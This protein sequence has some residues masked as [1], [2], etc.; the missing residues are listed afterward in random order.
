MIEEMEDFVKDLVYMAP[1]KECNMLR[2]LKRAL[3][4]ALLLLTAA[5]AATL[6]VLEITIESDEEIELTVNE[7]KFLSDELRRQAV[8]LLPKDYS[9]LTREKIIS[10]IPENAENLS[11]A[12]DIGKAIKSDYVT[13][14]SIDKLGGLFMLTVEL[15]ETSSG[16]ILGEFV[17]EAADYKGLL[18]AIREN[19]PNLF[20]KLMPETAGEPQQ[21]AYKAGLRLGAQM[22]AEVEQPASIPA[23]VPSVPKKSKNSVWVAIGLDALGAAALGLG[24]YSYAKAKSYYKDCQDLLADVPNSNEHPDEYERRQSDFT[25]KYGKVQ[26]AEKLRNIFYATGGALLSAGLAVHIWF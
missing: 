23:N 14:G 11:T 2:N 16:S 17:K 21:A 20:A 12:I 15:Y 7:T 18:D 6:A 24:V 13:R 1:K 3:I 10:L 25:A 9:V 8:R 22:E 4:T 5:N 26:D 19:A